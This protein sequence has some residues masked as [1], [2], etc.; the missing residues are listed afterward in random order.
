MGRVP[1][2]EKV[3]TTDF[4]QSGDKIFLVGKKQWDKLTF[5]E[6]TQEYKTSEYCID[7]IN[8]RR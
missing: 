6:Y 8:L 7:D 3:L 2:V 1:D 5:S 4:K